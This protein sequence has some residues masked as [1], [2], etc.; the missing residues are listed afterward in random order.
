MFE[1]FG[2]RPVDHPVA[3][4]PP[5]LLALDHPGGTEHRGGS[6]TGA[7][8]AAGA[9]DTAG[10]FIPV[11]TARS[12]TARGPRVLHDK[13]DLRDDVTGWIAG[14]DLDNVGYIIVGL[15][16]V[17]WVAAVAYWRLARVEQR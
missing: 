1:E 10:S 4:D 12:E 7:G 6:G 9:W 14:L 16:V 8:A 3:H 11:A 2:G 13:L 17:V 15:F 5:V